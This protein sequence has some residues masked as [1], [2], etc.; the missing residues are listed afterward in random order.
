MS[1][2]D[3]I[4]NKQAVSPRRP[5]IC[6]TAAACGNAKRKTPEQRADNFISKFRAD[7][8]FLA[9][10]E[11]KGFIVAEI[12][13]AVEAERDDCSNLATNFYNEK[14]L[15]AS[16]VQESTALDIALGISF[17]NK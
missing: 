5:L 12:R 16:M 10:R 14:N 15:P 13:E 8:P 3:N 2:K 6:S 7:I 11:M 1:K 4:D 9:M 17:R